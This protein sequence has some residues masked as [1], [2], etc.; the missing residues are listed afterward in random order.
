MPRRARNLWPQVVDFENLHLAFRKVR[1]GAKRFHPQLMR[2]YYALDDTLF[3]LQESLITHTWQPLPYREFWINE[4]KPRFI[5]AP[6]APDRVVHW[7]LM[8]QVGPVFERRFIHDSYACRENKGS[9]QASRRAQDFLRAATVQWGRPYILKC[10]ISKY[11]PSIDQRILMQRLERI[12]ADPDVLWLFDAIIRNGQAC[13][14]VGIPIGALTSQWLANVYLDA[15]DHFIKDDMGLPYYIRYMDDF[16]FM[17]PSRQWCATVL[18]QVE[19]FLQSLRLTLNPKTAIWPASHGLDF[20][21][22][23]H[24]TDHILPRK[25]TVKRARRLLR[26]MKRDFARG[27]IDT[28]YVRPR[29]ASFTGYMQHCDGHTTLEKMLE[30]FVLV[31]ESEE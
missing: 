31:R 16:V 30:D 9:H 11:F 5:S 17:G 10:D 15:L 14:S 20:V 8:L 29:V 21:G 6:A 26:A 18:A 4:V 2:M 1:H 7:A 23:R 19:K 25:R 12:I 24:W 3:A 28:E 13:P 27:R 22:Y